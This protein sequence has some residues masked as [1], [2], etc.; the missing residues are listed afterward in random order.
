MAKIIR[1]DELQVVVGKED[2]SI[3]KYN[4]S[5]C[6]F[7]PQ[8]DDEVEIFED[9]FETVITKRKS[10]FAHN[11]SY[12]KVE[13]LSSGVKVNKLFYCL[14]AFFLGS[15]GVQKFITG[16]IGAGILCLIFSWTA[17]PGIIGVIDGIRGL[18]QNEDENG[19]IIVNW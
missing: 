18:L 9:D 15:L 13:T 3:E 16:K 2:G 10:S 5:C 7:N 17:I 14:I 1:V 19:N 6:N 11:N 8:V 12:T 4:R